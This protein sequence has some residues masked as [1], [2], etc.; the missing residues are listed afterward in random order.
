MNKRQNGDLTVTVINATRGYSK[1]P[2]QLAVSC[3]ETKTAEPPS[4]K[5]SLPRKGSRRH[6][7]RF[8][9]LLLPLYIDLYRDG[10]AA[11]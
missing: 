5:H 4:A 9:R 10:V 8:L 3:P 7:I 1:A 2:Y 6:F 11:T